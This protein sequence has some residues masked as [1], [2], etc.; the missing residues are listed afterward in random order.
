MNKGVNA[1][2]Y[3]QKMLDRTIAPKIQPV[4]INQLPGG[5]EYTL[6][7]KLKWIS[8]T[9]GAQPVTS[10]E[11]IFNN[12]VPHGIMPGIPSLTFKM[13][14]E[15]THTK[16][17]HQLSEAISYYG[18]FFEIQPGANY[19]TL[20][21]YS[22]NKYLKDVL[23][24]IQEMVQESVL[25][26][27]EFDILKENTLNNI[28]INLEKTATLANI[29][30]K[31]LLFGEFHPYGFSLGEE[32]LQNLTISELRNYYQQFIKHQ[33]FLILTAGN[34]D[35]SRGEALDQTLG[36]MTLSK[37][38]PLQQ[39]AINTPRYAPYYKVEKPGSKQTSI[40]MGLHGITRKH[41]DYADLLVATEI[42]GGYFGS[43]LMQN[44]REEKGLT[45]GIYAQLSAFRDAAFLVVSSDVNK[46]NAQLAIDEVLKEI[47]IMQQEPVD[48]HE[49][50]TVRNYM[51]GQFAAQMNTPFAMAENVRTQYLFD[52]PSDHYQRLIHRIKT[53]DAEAIMQAMQKYWRT[54]DMLI[55][56]AG[57]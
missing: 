55:V 19:H 2:F 5:S 15:G 9:A 21:V 36:S 41:A 17:A 23:S 49:L 51:L 7:N 30:F 40:R 28:R 4:E 39:F 27:K 16:T 44:I 24:I 34:A 8:V 20:V 11:L 38:L 26:D 45:Y 35:S 37:A 6:N 10:V 42:L 50:D 57:A 18:A 3:L 32:H 53:I 43:R 47:K 33:P 56:E 22:M 48:A 13:L 52:L 14:S 31:N 25:P 1:P 46:E 29:K 54:E 12:Q